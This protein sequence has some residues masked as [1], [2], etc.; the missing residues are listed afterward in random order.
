M[1]CGAGPRAHEQNRTSIGMPVPACWKEL[2]TSTRERKL[3][4]H[5]R[6]GGLPFHVIIWLSAS[7]DQ[8]DN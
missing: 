3:K 1:H 7:R 2:L 5:Q 6:F 4:L 8:L